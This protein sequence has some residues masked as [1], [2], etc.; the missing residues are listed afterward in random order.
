ML[1]S[2]PCQTLLFRR[3]LRGRANCSYPPPISRL[4]R[5]L[6]QVG[7]SVSLPVGRAEVSLEKHPHFPIS[8]SPTLWHILET[9]FVFFLALFVLTPHL[10]PKTLSLAGWTLIQNLSA[11]GSKRNLPRR[12]KDPVGQTVP[13]S[14]PRRRVCS[15]SH[16]A[17]PFLSRP[18]CSGT[19][20]LSAHTN[21][22]QKVLFRENLKGF[23]SQGHFYI[24]ATGKRE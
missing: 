11:M 1:E 12:G 14:D 19:S 22:D 7:Y 6:F 9:F 24:F 16:P 20:S 17:R 13:L 2:C 3:T 5:F 10:F 23:R 15:P 21:N 18:I 8:S 4:V